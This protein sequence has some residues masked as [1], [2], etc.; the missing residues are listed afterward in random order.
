MERLDELRRLTRGA[1]A[2]MRA[3]LVELRPH[4]LIETPFAQLLSQLAL[5]M[6]VRG[7]VQIDVQAE[8]D[9]GPLPPEVQI[10]LYRITQE[11]LN[12]VVK[13]AAATRAQVRF[14]RHAAGADLRIRDDGRGFDTRRATPGHLGLSIM[15]ERARDISARLQVSSRVGSGTRIDVRWNET[16]Q[17]YA[18]GTG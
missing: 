1:L 11:A 17:G 18:S 3:L 16:T 14:R 7:T 5:S 4:A 8:T 9:E 13:H 15:R 2:E 6:S 12:N 10:G